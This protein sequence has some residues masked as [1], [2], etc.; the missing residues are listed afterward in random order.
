MKRRIGGYLA[1]L[2]C[3][4]ASAN[5][6]AANHDI[7]VGGAA[8][9]FAPSELTINVGDTVTFI[10][11]GGQHNVVAD[12]GS[13][14]CAAGC[15]TGGGGN[16]V[17]PGWFTTV[18]SDDASPDGYCGP[19]G[20][21]GCGNDDPGAPSSSAWRTTLT[22]PAAGT[23][24]YHCEA[25]GRP[26]SGM[27]GRIVVAPAGGAFRIGPS[28]TGNWYDPAQNGHG[29]QLEMIGETL[30][31]AIWFTFDGAGNPAWIVASGTVDGDRIVMQAGRSSGGRFPPNFDPAAIVARPWGT[32]TF[33]FTGCASGRLDWTSTDAA[34]TASGTLPL[35]RLTQ[36]HGAS[37]P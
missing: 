28:I 8:M 5:A 17:A 29:V 9:R 26:G 14:R 36:I 6:V 12:D 19:Y 7:A 18:K 34:F 25:H 23:V 3:L 20:G 15:S 10:N 24:G 2:A 33:T 16:R 13:F 1:A 11:A 22:F 27:Y 35:V 31:T 30:V 4:A 21:Y 37:C 32:L